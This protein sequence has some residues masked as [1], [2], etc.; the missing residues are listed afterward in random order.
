MLTTFEYSRI[1]GGNQVARRR[2]VTTKYEIIQVASEFFMSVGYSNTSPKM[3]SNERAFIGSRRGDAL[4]FSVENV[5][6]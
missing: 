3:I 6:G 2:V 5:R 4:R 1:E